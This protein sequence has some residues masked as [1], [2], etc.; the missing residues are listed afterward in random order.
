[1]ETGH[2]GPIVTGEMDVDDNMVKFLQSLTCPFDVRVENDCWMPGPL[3]LEDV[4]IREEGGEFVLIIT[5]EQKDQL[6]AMNLHLC[7]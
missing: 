4:G 3:V 2:L 1:M 6:A 7:G 5:E